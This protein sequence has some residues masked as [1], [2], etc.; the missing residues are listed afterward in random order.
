MKPALAAVVLTC[1]IQAAALAGTYHAEPR[2]GSD[3]ADG[4]TDQP[5]RTITHALARIAPGDTLVLRGGRYREQVR[6]SLVGTVR[7]PIVI[8]GEGSQPAVIDAGMPE[9]FDDPA[10]AWEPAGGDLYQSTRVYRNTTDI[11]GAFAHDPIPLVTYYLR[12]DLVST[13]QRAGFAPKPL[14]MDRDVY[15]GP[16]VW[17]DRQTGRILARLAHT[18]NGSRLTRD[19]AGP[20]D[21]RKVPLIIAAE[22][23]TPLTLDGARHVRIENV[24]LAGGAPDAV[25]VRDCA[26]VTLDRLVVQCGRFRGQT[27]GHVRVTNSRFIGTIP[28]WVWR[29]DASTGCASGEIRDVVRVWA[30]LVFDTSHEVEVRS[31][32]RVIANDGELDRP[33]GRQRVEIGTQD[34]GSPQMTRTPVNHDWEIAWCEFSDGHDGVY[35]AGRRMR[36]HHCAIDNMQDDSA[37]FSSPV[38]GI[39]DDVV[40]EANLIRRCVTAVSTHNQGRPQ[41]KVFVTG[42]V[43]DL[44]MP[45]AWSR[46]TDEK[47]QGE[48]HP[49]NC[50]FM[51]GADRAERVE[52]YFVYHN[53]LVGAQYHRYFY[54]HGFLNHLKPGSTRRVFNNLFVYLNAY[55]PPYLSK[56]LEGMD[57]HTDH[58]LH[59]SVAP[60]AQPP[61]NYL[62]MWRDSQYSQARSQENGGLWEQNSFVADPL[63]E[64][65][66]PSPEAVNDYRPRRGSRATG[67]ARELPGAWPGR[68]LS[69]IGALDT[70]GGPLRV[71]VD[72]RIVAGEP[73]AWRRSVLFAEDKTK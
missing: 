41:G 11:A 8:R 51:H 47:P 26:H 54:A 28:P 56:T 34:A 55:M 25:V 13:N 67:A 57:L 14:L 53:T 72:G 49:C 20:T 63:F 7:Q 58:N 66:A 52:S 45:M 22:R 12:S 73:W 62:E 5:W 3:E 36:M 40:F 18:R 42:N 10:G 27:S 69:T 37:D 68:R 9:F 44:R 6:C 33:R 32:P 39:V 38:P 50:F 21:P 71:G 24:T 46:P 30:P 64:A 43:I 23:A 35:P 61:A 48:G 19:Y 60:G 4:S 17:L 16:G 65:F 15:A 70:G 31:V 1:T 2:T 29:A 59:W